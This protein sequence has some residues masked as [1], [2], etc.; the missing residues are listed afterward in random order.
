MAS[1]VVQ[2]YNL[3]EKVEL[4]SIVP[5]TPTTIA[6]SGMLTKSTDTPFYYKNILIDETTPRPYLHNIARD[7]GLIER[8]AKSN[9]QL[10]HSIKDILVATGKFWNPSIVRNS[11]GQAFER[12][13][14]P[15]H[16]QTITINSEN[17]PQAVRDDD[18]D[19]DEEENEG[20]EAKRSKRG[21]R[22]GSTLQNDGEEPEYVFPASLQGWQPLGVSRDSLLRKKGKVVSDYIEQLKSILFRSPDMQIAGRKDIIPNIKPVSTSSIE[23]LLWRDCYDEEDEITKMFDNEEHR[24]E[25]HRLMRKQRKRVPRFAAY[26]QMSTNAKFN[27]LAQAVARSTTQDLFDVQDI[28]AS[29]ST[30]PL[31]LNKRIERGSLE[32]EGV[33]CSQYEGKTLVQLAITCPN[34]FVP[35][36]DSYRIIS[37]LLC[38][39]LRYDVPEVDLNQVD[40]TGDTALLIAMRRC[41][42]IRQE[43]AILREGNADP[44]TKPE[45]RIPE[46]TLNEMVIRAY[47]N[48]HDIILLLVNPQKRCGPYGGD[49]ESELFNPYDEY[50]EPLPVNV[51]KE[52]KGVSPLH[53]AVRSGCVQCLQF[54]QKHATKLDVTIQDQQNGRTALMDATLI[55]NP[56]M[57]F[58]LLQDKNNFRKRDKNKQSVFHIAARHGWNSGYLR[59]GE[60]M[61]ETVLRKWNERTGQDRKEAPTIMEMLWFA[62][63]SS[64]DGL[65]QKTSKEQEREREETKRREE[66]EAKSAFP[67]RETI[68]ARIQEV[69]AKNQISQTIIDAKNIHGLTALMISTLKRDK[70]AVFFLLFNCGA[71]PL[72]VVDSLQR[73]ALGML[74]NELVPELPGDEQRRNDRRDIID[75]LQSA[76]EGQ[77]KRLKA[78]R[79]EF[80]EPLPSTLLTG[81]TGSEGG[82]KLQN[83]QLV[84]ALNKIPSLKPYEREIEQLRAL[85]AEK[86]EEKQ[87]ELQ[88]EIKLKFLDR[89]IVRESCVI[90]MISS[91]E[92]EAH[93]AER[94]RIAENYGLKEFQQKL[95]DLEEKIKLRSNGN[96]DEKNTLCYNLFTFLEHY[97]VPTVLPEQLRTISNF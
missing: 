53:L 56:F 69:K 20:E 87:P 35:G 13:L 1:S 28:L 89:F 79:L 26:A 17:E 92:R 78:A 68:Q 41:N 86:L 16:E 50:Y 63:R 88:E 38:A 24:M 54:L 46:S 21:R 76:E 81:T 64:I 48:I 82:E 97:L 60:K 71:N 59:H 70:P 18:D 3:F 10:C 40:N 33:K 57:V 93:V 39:H 43:V 84:A 42:T 67:S 8:N 65:K 90:G 25:R 51:N 5:T 58:L 66:E 62:L 2:P 31:D 4:N 55:D 44:R 91:E 19:E 9:Q 6:Q 96:T 36:V 52:N 22:R 61:K 30:E 34:L 75:I 27:K 7:L 37:E 72:E 77:R 95:F 94:Y 49:A 73:T 14:Q 11:N 74:Q 12:P 83:E 29:L 47:Q 45:N 85:L 32:I 80:T 23:E 15:G